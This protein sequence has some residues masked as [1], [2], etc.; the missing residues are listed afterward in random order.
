M[1]A[2]QVDSHGKHGFTVTVQREQHV[3]C[4]I[5]I[6]LSEGIHMRLSHQVNNR[7]A[8]IASIVSATRSLT[9]I[10]HSQLLSSRTKPLPAN[11]AAVRRHD[12]IL[13]SM[14]CLFKA[15]RSRSHVQTPTLCEQYQKKNNKKRMLLP[16]LVPKC[17]R[18]VTGYKK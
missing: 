9:N 2:P 7:R 5:S 4:S 8:V 3:E 14:R 11:E 13:S 1:T 10:A 6:I 18:S 17:E 12:L 15:Q 16:L